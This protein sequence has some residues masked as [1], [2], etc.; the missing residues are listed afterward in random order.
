MASPPI[1]QWVTL[2]D[3]TVPIRSISSIEMT[4]E[5]GE[6]YFMVHCS[7]QKILKVHLHA[8][9]GKWLYMACHDGLAEAQ[10]GG[11]RYDRL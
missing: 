8:T 9:G 1:P 5:K 7:N 11:E 4:E 2:N 3:S 6:Y 10:R